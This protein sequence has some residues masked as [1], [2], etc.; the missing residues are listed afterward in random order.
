M[1]TKRRFSNSFAQR[2]W[3]GRMPECTMSG[4]LRTTCARP[5][6]A[7]RASWGV[8]PSYVNT[9]DFHVGSTHQDVRQLVQ[10]SQLILG[11]CL[12]RE[13]VKCSRGG[14]PEDR[15]HD[16]SVVTKGFT[17]GGGRR[18]HDVAAGKGVFDGR[19]LVRVGL[20]DPARTQHVP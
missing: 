10:L 19:R 14:I 2:G 15:T 1:T 17:G 6:M 4:L 7:R 13:K 12:G 9:P 3:C 16:R 8:S 18:N 11:E 5:R 20:G